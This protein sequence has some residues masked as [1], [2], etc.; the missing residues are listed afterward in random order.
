MIGNRKCLSPNHIFH[1]CTL[2]ACG[3]NDKNSET[4]YGLHRNPSFKC[5]GCGE[6]SENAENLCF[7]Q[8]LQ[9]DKD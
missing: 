6:T 3:L 2:K 5:E 4:F 7:P 9:K 8:E 1:M